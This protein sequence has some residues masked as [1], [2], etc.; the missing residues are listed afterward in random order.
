MTSRR[1]LI[2]VDGL[3]DGSGAAPLEHAAIL[4]EGER[5]LAAGRRAD[6]GRPDGATRI[7][8]A[9]GSTAM[10]GLID[11]HVHLASSGQSGIGAHRAERLEVGSRAA[12]DARWSPPIVTCARSAWTISARSTVARRD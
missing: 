12:A 9:P 4:I 10:P 1:R 7:E 8:A 2:E 11:S 3:I 6:L 5:I